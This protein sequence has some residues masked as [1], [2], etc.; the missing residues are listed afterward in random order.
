MP[1]VSDDQLGVTAA[2]LATCPLER[3]SRLRR[4]VDADRDPSPQLGPA[5]CIAGHDN[6]RS[7]AVMQAIGRHR[8]AQVGVVT[9]ADDEQVGLPCA[10][11]ENRPGVSVQRCG[12]D[13]RKARDITSAQVVPQ[14][15]DG[16]EV[17]RDLQLER[18]SPDEKRRDVTSG[19][20]RLLQRPEQCLPRCRGPVCPD[21]DLGHVWPP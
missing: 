14:G 11:N 15:A 2:R 4:Q 6:D 1:G 21:H 3:D 20:N 13:L 19:A 10:F 5:R 7:S 17:E 8:A 9:R 18:Y 12:R 16:L